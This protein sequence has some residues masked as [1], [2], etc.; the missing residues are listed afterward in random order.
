V[1]PVFAGC[2]VILLLLIVA[3]RLWM[4]PKGAPAAA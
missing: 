2:T 3:G 1:R 4:E